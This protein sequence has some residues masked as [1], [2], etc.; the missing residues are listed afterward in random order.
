[1][2]D[3]LERKKNFLKYVPDVSNSLSRLTTR[4]KPYST[5]VAL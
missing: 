2:K 3:E 1:M 5:R 4:L